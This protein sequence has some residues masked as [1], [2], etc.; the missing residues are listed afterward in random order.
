MIENDLLRWG[1]AAPLLAASL[2]AAFRAGRTSPPAIRAGFGLHAA[3]MTAMVLMLVPGLQWPALPQVFVFGLAAWWF[4]LRAVSRRPGP[5]WWPPEPVAGPPV[6][7]RPGHGRPDGQSG[8]GGLLYH[9]LTMAAMAYMPAA[10]DVR[11]AHGP[12]AAGVEAAGILGQAA[13]H[14]GAPLAGL[15]MQGPN[16]VWVSQV[17]LVLAVAFGLAAAVWA[18]FLLRSHTG[19][20]RGGTG[21][22][23]VGAA[24]MAV[25][26]AALAA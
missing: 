17:A 8:R 3:M 18:V 24:S 20:D 11:S 22:E 23:L 2:Y 6:P 7:E 10:M 14:G 16:Q 21:L 13:H 26:F 4:V 25:M 15:P 19:R 1:L 5:H 9:A 12:E